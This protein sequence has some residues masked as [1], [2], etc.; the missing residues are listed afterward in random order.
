[1]NAEDLIA[2][3]IA[4]R[5]ISGLSVAADLPDRDEPFVSHFTNEADRDAYIAR[6][7]ARGENPRIIGA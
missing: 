7:T 2:R 1:M 5:T 6:C 3:A 4:I